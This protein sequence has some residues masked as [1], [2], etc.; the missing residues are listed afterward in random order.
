MC[1]YVLGT[2]SRESDP[3]SEIIAPQS[4]LPLS[5]AEWGNQSGKIQISVSPQG[6]TVTQQ[7]SGR[8]L[9]SPFIESAC[10]RP[11][12][13]M[14]IRKV[15]HPVSSSVIAIDLELETTHIRLQRLCPDIRAGDCMETLLRFPTYF[16]LSWSNQRAPSSWETEAE[17]PLRGPAPPSS[18]LS[19]CRPAHPP[20][21]CF[22]LQCVHHVQHSHHTQGEH[23]QIVFDKLRISVN[24]CK[25]KAVLA[26]VPKL[27]NQH[28]SKQYET[29]TFNSLWLSFSIEYNLIFL[30]FGRWEMASTT[31]LG[32]RGAHRNLAGKKGV[33]KS[34]A[35]WLQ[36]SIYSWRVVV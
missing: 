35:M 16:V 20:S 24:S 13:Y 23:S 31:Q 33:G 30:A 9:P 10:M 21:C 11:M 2:I 28:T 27:P 14:S 19:L 6:T 18:S 5:P 3:S 32:G 36:S 8:S 34:V 17:V 12:A 1:P 4:D 26:E 15:L 29:N 25:V 22:S 7:V